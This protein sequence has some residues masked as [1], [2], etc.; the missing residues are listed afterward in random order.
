MADTPETK[1][2]DGRLH[3]KNDAGEFVGVPLSMDEAR[4]AKTKNRISVKENDPEPFKE[5]NGLKPDG[6]EN[7]KYYMFY[8]GAGYDR[9]RDDILEYGSEV[10]MSHTYFGSD[11][12][13]YN[14][15]YNGDTVVLYEN[16]EDLPELMQ[17]DAKVEIERT[18][19]SAKT[20][21][22]CREA[23]KALQDQLMSDEEFDALEP[24]VPY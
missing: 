19:N 14:G 8:V 22:Q 1:I 7:G 21:A 12:A 18:Q 3:I 4:S 10:G 2:I 11:S 13:G 5:Y 20:D 17:K 24:Y 6:G 23:A 16:L 15:F 9:T